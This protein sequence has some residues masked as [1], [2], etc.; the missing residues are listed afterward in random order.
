MKVCAPFVSNARDSVPVGHSQVTDDIERNQG[1]QR[2]LAAAL[3]ATL[4]HWTVFSET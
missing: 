1:I 2:A 3:D 4:I